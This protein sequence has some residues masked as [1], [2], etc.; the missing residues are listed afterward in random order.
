MIKR[1]AVACP[2]RV[3]GTLLEV[4]QSTAAYVK[5]LWNQ[6]PALSPHSPRPILSLGELGALLFLAISKLAEIETSITLPISHP[7]QHYI[8][9]IA[10][11]RDNN[12]AKMPKC[13]PLPP[14]FNS[15]NARF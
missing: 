15:Q 4:T 13:K 5:L 12:T 8:G 6:L 7:S 11:H 1:P 9:R 10:I 14:V 2:W 3:W